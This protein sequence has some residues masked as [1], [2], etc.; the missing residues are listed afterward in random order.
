MRSTTVNL[1]HP[2]L[3]SRLAP[4]KLSSADYRGAK[5]SI[6]LRTYRELRGAAG[7]D[8]AA[9]QVGVGVGLAGNLT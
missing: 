9:Q 2:Q 1:G 5:G 8:V 7:L 6:E 3:I 4:H